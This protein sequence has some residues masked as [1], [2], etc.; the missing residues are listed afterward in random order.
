MAGLIATRRVYVRTATGV[1]KV[2]AGQQVPE[3]ADE[4]RVERLNGLGMVEAPK[5]K[6]K[7]ASTTKE[8]G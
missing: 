5:P 1:V 4:S 3:S 8:K 7:P 6:P 2:D